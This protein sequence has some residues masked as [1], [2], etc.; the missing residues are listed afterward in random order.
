MTSSPRSSFYIYPFF[1]LHL[2]LHHRRTPLPSMARFFTFLLIFSVLSASFCS[3]SE[4]RKLRVGGQRS[5]PIVTPPSRDSLFLSALPKGT[6]PSSTPSKKGHAAV[7]DEKL[8]ARHLIVMDRLLR[9]VPSPG[10]G[11]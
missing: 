9:S 11:H 1:P 2:L 4:A 6:V 7:V 10:A 8:V 5:R 3:F